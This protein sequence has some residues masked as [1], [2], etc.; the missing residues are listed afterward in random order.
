[1]VI[2]FQDSGITKDF[3]C[4]F[5]LDLFAPCAISSIFYCVN[6]GLPSI[7]KVFYDESESVRRRSDEEVEQFRYGMK[8]IS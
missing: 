8:K 7:K 4:L 3:P 6:L 2:I 1:M 5:E